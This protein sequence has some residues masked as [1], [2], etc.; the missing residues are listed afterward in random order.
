MKYFY[1]PETIF[2]VAKDTIFIWSV[3]SSAPYFDARCFGCSKGWFGIRDA[4]ENALIISPTSFRRRWTI[5]SDGNF[6]ANEKKRRKKKK[7]NLNHKHNHR[8]TLPFECVCNGVIMV[9]HWL[10]QE[11]SSWTQSLCVV[12]QRLCYESYKRVKNNWTPN[13][14]CIVNLW[15]HIHLHIQLFIV[16]SLCIEIVQRIRPSTLRLW[17]NRNIHCTT[18]RPAQ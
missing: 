15:L 1:A 8:G 5:I 17:T 7:R 14:D 13:I 11:A 12:M 18:L 16:T 3:S 10:H 4:W 6:R 9:M 2:T